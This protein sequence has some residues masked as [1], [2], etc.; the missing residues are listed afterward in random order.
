M[1]KPSSNMLALRRGAGQADPTL[2]VILEFQW[3]STA[4]ANAQIPRS[5]RGIAWIVS[6][7]VFLLIAVSGLIP[8]DRVVSARGIVVSQSP[9]IL[10]Q[11]L[12]TAIVRSIDVREGQVVQKG[13]VLARLDPTFATADAG[14][15][16]VQVAALQAEVA[17]LKAEALGEPFAYKGD[18]PVMALQAS[19]FGLRQAERTA[20]LDNYAQKIDALKASVAYSE[21]EAAMYSQRL[22]VAQQIESM[23]KGLEKLHFDSKLN[24]LIATDTRLQ[25][26]SG[27]ANARHDAAAAR[28]E[29]AGMQAERDA[30][31]Q[32]WKAEVSQDLADKTQKLNDARE[33]L[34]KAKLRR[35]LVELHADREAIVQS[36]AKVSVGSVLQSG[37][38]VFTLVPVDAPLEIEANV[39]GQENGFVNVGDPVAIKF[40]TFPYAQYGMA[41]GTV[42]TVSPDSF[43]AQDEAR[44][45]TSALP[46]AAS[47]TEP[48]YRARITID[49]NRLHDVPGGFRM[50]PGMPVTADIK[51]G[52]RTVLGYLLGQMLPVAREGMR[53]P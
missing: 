13:E 52:Q 10:V 22:E 17:R 31:D 12:E 38:Q 41:E 44:N 40:D 6:S 46:M 33:S 20:R 15:L 25:I 47:S 53:E 27:L 42:R 2:P 9:K 32:N 18:D 28:K 24:F 7:M 34:S 30:Y 11:P 5:A 51:V 43:S 4:I 29:L 3:P 14:A 39:S 8:I 37:Q 49:K 48:F 35:N 19:I 23:R 16:A 1:A 26:E 50:M 45:P 21:A 36:I